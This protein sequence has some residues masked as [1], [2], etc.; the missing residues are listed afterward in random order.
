MT[1]INNGYNLI[2]GTYGT[3]PY[4]SDSDHGVTVVLDTNLTDELIEEGLTREIISK[5]QT[6]RKDAGFDVTDTINVYEK[7]ND[8]IKA[9]MEK[10]ADT[11]KDDVLGMNIIFGETKGFEKKWNINGEEAT[12]SVEKL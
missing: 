1:Q 11:I 5:I 8:K 7:D 6:M 10:N 4:V 2:S 3:T 9:V 12:L